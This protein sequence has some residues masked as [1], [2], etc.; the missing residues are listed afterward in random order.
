MYWCINVGA[1]FGL[2][3]TYSERFVGFWLA[4]LEPG[5]LYALSPLVLIWASKKLYKAPPQGSVFMEACKVFARCCKNGGWKNMFKRKA[6]FWDNAKPSVIEAQE[7]TV[8]RSVIFWDDLFVEEIKQS[9]EACGVF[10]LIPIFLLAD[11]GIGAMENTMSAAM[12]LDGVPNDVINNFNSLTIIVFTPIFTWGIYPF[13]ERIG[14]PLKPMTRMFIGFQL[15]TINMIA[16]A[17]MQWR[18]YETSPCG[19]EA[20]TCAEVAPVSLWWQII[21]YG[22]PAIGEILVMVT[23]YE[24]AYT[25]APARMKGLVYGLCLFN[26]AIAAIIGL[27]AA[28]AIQ[29]PYLIWPYVALACASFVTAFIFPTYYRHLNVPMRLFAD[30]VRQAGMDQPNYKAQV[31]AEEEQALGHQ[32]QGEVE[33]KR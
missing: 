1:M 19:Y 12:R 14:Y 7:G 9:V 4:Y 30:P 16:G 25:R 31:M 13:F 27:A 6:S 26:S 11:G 33:S 29:D 28:D 5:I 21:L 32:N 3:T 24:I 2:A 18:I 22:V 8:D 23:S 10:F 17:I 20:S 15:G